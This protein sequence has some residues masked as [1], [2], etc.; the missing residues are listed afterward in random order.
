M[1]GQSFT[2]TDSSNN[3]LNAP[4]SGGGT[5]GEYTRASGFLSYYEICQR[6][7]RDRWTVVHDSEGSMGPYAYNGNQWVSYDD[8]PM[9][10]KKSELI[11]SMGLGGGMIWA[12]DLDDFRNVC[13]QGKYPLL[14]TINSVLGRKRTVLPGGSG[15]VTSGVTAGTRPTLPP[16]T[17]MP[18]LVAHPSVVSIVV[19]QQELQPVKENEPDPCLREPYKAHNS[20]CR[21]YYR[22]IFGKYVEQTCPSGTY[23]NKVCSGFHW[24]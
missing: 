24:I 14:S 20:N 16:S 19:H 6:V 4:S 11:K 1:Y 3:G 8:V 7:Q 9:I 15:G 22:C 21:K 12:L 10:R 2:L 5:A 17:T 18:N 13:G 23:W